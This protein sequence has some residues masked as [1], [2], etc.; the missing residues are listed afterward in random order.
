MS[1]LPDQSVRVNG[2]GA[3]ADILNGALGRH[4]S[5][6]HDIIKG[7]RAL[8]PVVLRAGLLVGATARSHPWGQGG[9]VARLEKAELAPTQ[10]AFHLLHVDAPA[11][12]RRWAPGTPYVAPS[13]RPAIR[14]E[15]HGR[16]LCV[17]HPV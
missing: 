9:P 8:S 4:S 11:S 5:C 13:G 12:A 14:P 10:A 7:P 1:T 17:L 3:F 6:R 2:C 16:S 15:C